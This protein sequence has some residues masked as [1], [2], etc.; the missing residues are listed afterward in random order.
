MTEALSGLNDFCHD[1][2]FFVVTSSI[3]YKLTPVLQA[4]NSNFFMICNS[5]AC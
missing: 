3:L 2:S 5:D 4:L 1:S